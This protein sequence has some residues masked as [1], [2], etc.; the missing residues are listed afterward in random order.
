[1]VQIQIL[2]HPYLQTL[3][4]KSSHCRVARGNLDHFFSFFPRALQQQGVQILVPMRFNKW[5]LDYKMA[6]TK[7]LYSLNYGRGTS[8]KCPDPRSDLPL[9][10]G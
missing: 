3:G 10:M 6:Y 1:M 5:S 9:P 4:R 7:K 8:L 2:T